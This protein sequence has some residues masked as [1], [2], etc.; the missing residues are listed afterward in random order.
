MY[1]YAK[2]ECPVVSNN[3]AHRWTDDVP[4]I[5]PEINHEHIKIIDSQKKR[6]GTKC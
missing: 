5:I 4:I 3:S 2:H 1:E 6:I